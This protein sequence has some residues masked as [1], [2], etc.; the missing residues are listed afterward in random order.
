MIQSYFASF[1]CGRANNNG[2]ISHVQSTQ[3]N[4]VQ[5]ERRKRRA[6]SRWWLINLGIVGESIALKTN[7]DARY[8]LLDPY[9][10]F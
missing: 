2:N 6:A 3:G 5:I 1:G 10:I 4:G 8:G 7:A 9:T